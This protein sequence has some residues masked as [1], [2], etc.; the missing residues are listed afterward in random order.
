M[1]A[2]CSAWTLMLPLGCKLY[3]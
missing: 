3:A 1:D 2:H